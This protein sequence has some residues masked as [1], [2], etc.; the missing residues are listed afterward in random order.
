[1]INVSIRGGSQKLGE[2]KSV[3]E[4]RKVYYYFSNC[5]EPLLRQ[6]DEGVVSSR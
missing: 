3:A 4:M 6:T 2:S 1:M 5:F